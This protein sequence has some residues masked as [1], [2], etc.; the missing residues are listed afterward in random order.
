MTTAGHGTDA[1]RGKASQHLSV[2]CNS[3]VRISAFTD[4]SLPLL[5]P[6]AAIRL[7]THQ[8]R[9]MAEAGRLD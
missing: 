1:V 6:K 4:K 8:G 2:R 9:M 7:P 3:T 5:L